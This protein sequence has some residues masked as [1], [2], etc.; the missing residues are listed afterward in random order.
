M[1]E[2]IKLAIAGSSGRMGR[3]II[4]A[5]LAVADLQI[6]A[7]LDRPDCPDLGQDC[8]QFLGKTIGVPIVADLSAIRGAQVLIDFTRPLAT[9]AHLAICAEHGIGAVIGTTGFDSSGKAA[10]A[11]AAEKTALVVAPNMSVGVQAMVRLVE[12]GARLLA[13]G[14]DLE[15]IET[16][17]RDKV[18]APS[19][20]AL[21]LGE[22]AAR[23][24]G[25]RLESCAVFSRHGHTGARVEGSIGFSAIRGGDII[26]DHTVLFAGTGERIEITHRSSNRQAYALGALRAA[27]FLKGRALGL[28]N[29]Q[30]VLSE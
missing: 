7:A 5:A 9:L 1:T 29:M 21:Q 18:D 25:Q 24:R 10:L 15:I 8:A 30:D 20:T 11:A 3:T 19:G 26:G 16:H 27:R 22:A 14:Y 13:Q 2:K 4:E 12:L 17:H 23:A 6:V 28:Y